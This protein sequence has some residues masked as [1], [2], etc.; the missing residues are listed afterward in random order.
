VVTDQVV[1]QRLD[2]GHVDDVDVLA[3]GVGAE[4]DDRQG[5]EVDV[6][7][8]QRGGLL[9]EGRSSKPVSAAIGERTT[10]PARR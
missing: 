2:L 7:A 1:H 5:G 10:P 4:A 8:G 6:P 3:G 9:S